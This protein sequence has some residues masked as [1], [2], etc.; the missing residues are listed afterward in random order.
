[1]HGGHD[2]RGIAA[3]RREESKIPAGGPGCVTWHAALEPTHRAAAH[4]PR[5][6]QQRWSVGPCCP[7]T[8]NLLRRRLMTQRSDP[9]VDRGQLAWRGSGVHNAGRLEEH[10]VTFFRR[11]R[12]MLGVSGDHEELAGTQGDIVGT[13]QLN[14][15][16]PGRRPR[17]PRRSH[18]G[19]R[20]TRRS[21][22][23]GLDCQPF[24]SA[25]ILGDQCSVK[26]PNFWAMSTGPPPPYAGTAWGC[27]VMIVSLF[28]EAF[29]DFADASLRPTTSD[30]GSHPGGREMAVGCGP[31]GPRWSDLP[32][33]LGTRPRMRPSRPVLGCVLWAEG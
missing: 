13:S 18:A 12:A 30:P 22:S 2:S 29:G 27:S 25:M 24:A 11:V 32:A 8:A 6:T 17:T 20:R 21:P 23:R 16:M 5:G 3:R 26:R 15:D 28:D 1:M 9:L 19:A 4:G 31:A 33:L 10:Q 14:G 7:G